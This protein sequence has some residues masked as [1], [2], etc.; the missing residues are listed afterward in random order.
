MWVS[1][2]DETSARAGDGNI[3]PAPISDEAH[4]PR[5]IGPHRRQEYHLFLTPLLVKA[6][7]FHVLFVSAGAGGAGKWL[8]C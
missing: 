1:E 6:E 8:T 7:C 2:D 4:R 5:A 3:E